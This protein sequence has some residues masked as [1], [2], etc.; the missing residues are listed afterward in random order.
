MVILL[1]VLVWLLATR[2]DVGIT[3]LRVP[4]Q[5]FQE[6]P[7]KT[8]SNLYTYKMLNKTFKNKE[9]TLKAENFEGEIRLVGE[10]KFIIPKNGY[11]LGTM[12]I[13]INDNEVKKRKT[14]LK[15]GV[16]EGNKKINTIT[17]SFLGPFR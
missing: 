13:Y 16:Y 17:T 4:G 2:S 11:T 14:T 8:M 15:I 10:N 7:N 3:V 5:L 9:V 1:T 12:F 6:W